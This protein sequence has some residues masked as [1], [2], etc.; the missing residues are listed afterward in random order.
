M[1]EDRYTVLKFRSNY[2]VFEADFAAYNV[3]KERE[4]LVENV[5]LEEAEALVKLLNSTTEESG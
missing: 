1:S 3:F 2:L 4:R 5:S